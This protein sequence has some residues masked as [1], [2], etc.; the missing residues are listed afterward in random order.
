[1]NKGPYIKTE[2]EVKS[3][4]Q[5]YLNEINYGYNHV[6][7]PFDHPYL[8]WM[9]GLRKTNSSA[10]KKQ[11]HE[12]QQSKE[13][14]QYQSYL[15]KVKAL[16]LVKDYLAENKDKLSTEHKNKL[17]TKILDEERRL[18]KAEK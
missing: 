12:V 10:M 7:S 11:E 16:N 8:Q 17:I 1:M 14:I 6:G 9:D 18:K 4:K 13:D 3:K 15:S 2:K 5:L